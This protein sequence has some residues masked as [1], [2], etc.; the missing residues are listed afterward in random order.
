MKSN[1]KDLVKFRRLKMMMGAPEYHVIGLLESLWLFTAKNA[2]LGNVG[3]YTNEDIAAMVDWQ[4]SADELVRM[5]TEARWLDEHPSHRLVVHD[6]H[7]HAPN[8]V[9][10]N[11]KQHMGG[12][13]SSL[14]SGVV[15]DQSTTR[16]S[17]LSEAPSDHPSDTPKDTPKDGPSDR[18]S[19]TP[20][21]SSQ[22]KPSQAQSNLKTKPR[23]VKPNQE[24]LLVEKTTG[25]LLPGSLPDDQET[26][27]PP[28]PFEYSADFEAFWTAYPKRR[29]VKKRDA[30]KAWGLAITRT[31][32]QR[33]ILAAQ[34]YAASAEGLGDFCPSPTPWLNG[35]RW[36][37]DRTS[38]N[39]RETSHRERVNTGSAEEAKRM[40]RES[41]PVTV[42]ANPQRIEAEKLSTEEIPF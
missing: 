23:P 34:E 4:G 5:L 11:V 20:T 21:K 2:P 19:D 42:D 41:E 37:D 1:T 26:N 14:R 24:K 38:W 30:W 36:E 18:P 31:H 40:L 10:A 8:Y 32:P 28:K 17:G 16:S 27:P 22:V 9:K 15:V 33:I 13:W 39:A 6:W 3:K 12:D 7:D 35:D 29:R 25:S